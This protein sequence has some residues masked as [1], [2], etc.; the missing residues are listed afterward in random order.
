M[1]NAFSLTPSD[2]ASS[3]WLR[4]KEHFEER[5]ADARRRNDSVALTPYETSAVR[6][7]I[8]ALK[9]L[10]DEAKAVEEGKRK[11]GALPKR[12]FAVIPKDLV[13]KDALLG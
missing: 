1:T 8:K 3:L 5:L 6:G 9:G 12:V 7:E 2:K 10:I 4:L 13:E 11:D